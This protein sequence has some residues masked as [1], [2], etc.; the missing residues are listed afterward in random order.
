MILQPDEEKHRRQQQC[1]VVRQLYSKATYEAV[2]KY[3]LK[4]QSSNVFLIYNEENEKSG[5]EIESC[6]INEGEDFSQ[7]TTLK[8]N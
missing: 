6:F 1:P 7:K 2:W 4:M 8:S 5:C 3:T